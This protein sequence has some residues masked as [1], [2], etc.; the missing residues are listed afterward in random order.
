M[1]DVRYGVVH[2]GFGE[3]P[4]NTTFRWLIS[5]LHPRK[6]APKHSAIDVSRRV[7]TFYTQK[8]WKRPSGRGERGPQSQA[9]SGNS[10]RKSIYCMLFS[11][12]INAFCSQMHA[13]SLKFR[14]IN[15]NDGFAFVKV[16]RDLIRLPSFVRMLYSRALSIA[17]SWDWY[18]VD[19]LDIFKISQQEWFAIGG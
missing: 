9:K 6:L 17:R 15:I 18:K 8:I 12:K 16:L 7:D 1:F 2:V 19:N 11:M 4:E 10:I 3:K 5:S 14:K 13:N